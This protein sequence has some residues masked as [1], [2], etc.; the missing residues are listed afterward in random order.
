M[1]YQSIFER[2]WPVKNMPSKKDDKMYTGWLKIEN[3]K[4]YPTSDF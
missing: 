4:V 1:I 3:Q 2:S